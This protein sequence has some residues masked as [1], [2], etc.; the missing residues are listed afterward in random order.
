MRIENVGIDDVLTRFGR[1]FNRQR[2]V[3]GY[4]SK[5]IESRLEETGIWYPHDDLHS[6]MK[7]PK[8]KRVFTEKL[9]EKKPIAFKIAEENYL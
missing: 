1:W 3:L 7:A 5:S 8:Q 4:P 6:Y 2:D 9:I